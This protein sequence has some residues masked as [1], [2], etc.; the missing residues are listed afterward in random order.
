M[1]KSI[2]SIPIGVAADSKVAWSWICGVHVYS[3]VNI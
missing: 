1:L 2:I 3:E